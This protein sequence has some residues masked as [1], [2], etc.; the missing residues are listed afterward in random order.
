[1][2]AGLGI[3]IRP[4]IAPAVPRGGHVRV[5][6]EDAPRGSRLG[7]RQWVEEAARAFRAAGA[8]VNQ[9]L[10]VGG[11]PSPRAP[12]MRFGAPGAP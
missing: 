4:L 6:P 10:A 3:D 5:G 2:V 8:F 7:N 12:H 1:M 9:T 11:A